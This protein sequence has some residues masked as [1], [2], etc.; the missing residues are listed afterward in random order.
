MK[1]EKKELFFNILIVVLVGIG[2]FLTLNKHDA[3]A[4]LLTKGLK[5]FKYY[6]VLSNVFAGIVSAMWLGRALA[7]R[8]REY[9][10][11]P[12]YM[13]VLRL[14]AAAA[15]T[16]T[17]LTIACFLGPIYGHAHMYHN[18]NFFF[19]LVVPIV[20][21]IA[22][23]FS[24]DAKQIPFKATYGAAVFTF[25]YGS[26]YLINILVNGKGVGEDSNDW[27]GFLN[28]GMPIGIVIFAFITLTAWGVALLLRFI[29]NRL[30][31]KASE[32]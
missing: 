28:W 22:Y 11:D 1:I 8:G 10:P 14:T 27:Y 4:L 30:K 29:A 12:L 31:R 20:A 7:F 6:T 23:F 26:I 18:A 16:V 25:L 3:G 24:G 21:F 17:F 15:V 19:H 5:N 32:K 9:D 2:V 13:K